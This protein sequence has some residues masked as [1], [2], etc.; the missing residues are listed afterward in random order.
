MELVKEKSLIRVEMEYDDGS[1]RYLDGPDAQRWIDA[2]TTL[3]FLHQVRTGVLDP[4]LEAIS[5]KWKTGE[6]GQLPFPY[7]DRVDERLRAFKKKGP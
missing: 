7:G 3:A 4:S 6:R 1:I 2:V 5:K